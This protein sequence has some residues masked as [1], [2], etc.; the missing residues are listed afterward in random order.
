MKIKISYIYIYS[1]QIYTKI[2]IFET[3]NKNILFQ[4]REFF[5]TKSA[6]I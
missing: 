6:E 4:N 5:E 3:R 2:L 1:N